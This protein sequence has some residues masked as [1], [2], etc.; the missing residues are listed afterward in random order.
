MSKN[1]LDDKEMWMELFEFLE[2]NSSQED[3]DIRN[4]SLNIFAGIINN[5]GSQFS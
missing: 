5:Y 3:S 2:S 1:F 4:T